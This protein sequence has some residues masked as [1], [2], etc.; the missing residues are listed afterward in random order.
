MTRSASEVMNCHK[1][2][3]FPKPFSLDRTPYTQVDFEETVKNACASPVSLVCGLRMCKVIILGDLSVGKTSIVNR[4]C[5]QSFDH[6]YK[7][8]IGVDFEIEQFNVLQIPFN[9]QI[10]D[11]AGQ[12]RFRCI[13]AA[14]FRRAH[15]FDLTNIMSLHNSL[16]WLNEALKE[17]SPTPLKFLVGTKRDLMKNSNYLKVEDYASKMAKIVGA[18]YWAVSSRTGDGIKELFSRVAALSFER[19][20]KAELENPDGHVKLQIGESL[21]S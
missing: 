7:A 15:V 10:W 18:E 2:L 21:L 5:R 3:E 20:I 12:E 1:I 6:N 17:N 9:V 8:T 14:Y 4:F 11:T 16:E 13:A 19:I